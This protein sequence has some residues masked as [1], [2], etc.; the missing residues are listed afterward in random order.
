MAPI[1]QGCQ[2]WLP[3]SVTMESGCCDRTGEAVLLGF[4][5]SQVAFKRACNGFFESLL[6]A[7]KEDTQ[8]H[9][10]LVDISNLEEA[11]CKA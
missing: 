1:K 8:R 2:D 10:R 5:C 11:L 3:G 6:K 9:M 7:L 4:L